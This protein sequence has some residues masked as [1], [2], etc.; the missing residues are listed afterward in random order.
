MKVLK[1]IVLLGVMFFTIY[2]CSKSI[3][4]STASTK[5]IPLITNKKKEI[6]ETVK[7]KDTILI[8]KDLTEEDVN[9]LIQ[10]NLKN[11]K[12]QDFTLIS[13]NEIKELKKFIDSISIENRNAFKVNTKLAFN[14]I[15]NQR[16]ILS[17]RELLLIE[18]ENRLKLEKENKE[19]KQESL[20]ETKFTGIIL[21]TGLLAN[22]LLTA[23]LIFL[24][25]KVEHIY[26]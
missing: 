8:K 20:L 15:F 22:I 24:K 17:E 16:K 5:V 13:N 14:D 11:Y 4:N 26:A 18:R 19:I 2:S 3:T 9:S 25:K 6:K 10:L 1:I 12:H 7:E 23:Y 21:I